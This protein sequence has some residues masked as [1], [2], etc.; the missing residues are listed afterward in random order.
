MKDT[1]LEVNNIKLRM[2][3][4]CKILHSRERLQLKNI[5]GYDIL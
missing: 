3:F 1:E 2:I 5:G 4:N